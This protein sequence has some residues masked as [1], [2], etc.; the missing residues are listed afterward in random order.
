MI[1]VVDTNAVLGA[2]TEKH[3]HRPLLDAAFG[4]QIVWAVSTDILLEYEE[5]LAQRSGLARA[6][7]AMHLVETMVDAGLCIRTTLHYRW[8]LIAA[9]PDDDKFAD[10]AIAAEADWIITED[11]HFDVLKGSG[12]KPQP[13]TPADFIARFLAA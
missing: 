1:V 7:Q 2:F 13:I 11:A 9:D 6:T 5:I 8:R 4:G 3:A 10:C 12:Y